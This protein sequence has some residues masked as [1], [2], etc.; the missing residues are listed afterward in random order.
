MEELDESERKSILHESINKGNHKSALTEEYR[1]TVTKL[2]KQ[3]VELG[4][5]I[6]LSVECIKQIPGA[7]VYPVGCQHQWTIDENGNS[8]PKKRV[9][10]DLS[11][12]KKSKKSVNQRVKEGEIPEVIYGHAM[13]RFLHL[14]HH[15]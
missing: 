8:I 10:H 11:F 15:L 1:P 12:N 7:E 6:P 9:T 4:Y 13:L 3:D 14:I 2:M 5:G